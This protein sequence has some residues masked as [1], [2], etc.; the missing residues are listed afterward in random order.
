MK[1][2]ITGI[3][4]MVFLSILA[5]PLE[6]AQT[7][8]K[9]VDGN[10][11]Y[12]P[13]LIYQS[14]N[15]RMYFGG[16]MQPNQVHDKIYRATCL[17]PPLPCGS[18]Q[19]VLDSPNISLPVSLCGGLSP[20]TFKHLNDPIVILHPSGNYFIIYMTGVTRY[21]DEFDFRT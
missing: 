19:L 20:C 5:I 16:W 12:S 10:V 4:V 2:V 6:A 14:S 7:H 15:L 21:D 8:T 9:V 18:V 17:N 1:K 13:S 11:I 3:M